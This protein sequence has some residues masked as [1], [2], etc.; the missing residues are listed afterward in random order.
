MVTPTVVVT[1]AN[2]G[3]GLEF[4]RQYAADGWRVHA[5]C[6]DPEGADALR[7][8]LLGHNAVIHRL[9]IVDPASIMAFAQAIEDEP[10]DVLINNA[11]IIGGDR[12]DVGNVDYAMWERTV[13]TNVIGLFR[14]AEALLVRLDAGDKRIIANISSLMGSITDNGS[15]G[16]HIYRT[17]KTALNMVVQNMAR[18]LAPRGITVLAFHPGWVRTDMGG[19]NAP[20]LPEDSATGMRRQ[21]DAAGPD[22]SGRFLNHDGR[23]LPW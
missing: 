21:I 17:S 23:E 10:V 7:K 6:R 16:D 11:G 15:G 3:I 20:V 5:A 13:R 18:D 14:V 2:R 1:G 12:Q 19:D 9:D 4:A 8:T 22:Q